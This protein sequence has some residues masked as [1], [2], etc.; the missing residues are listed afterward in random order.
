V[1]DICLLRA[2]FNVLVRKSYPRYNN[3]DGNWLYLS[4]HHAFKKEMILEQQKSHGFIPQICKGGGRIVHW[5][6]DSKY[7]GSE[8]ASEFQVVKGVSSI[9]LASATTSPKLGDT[10]TISG[11]LIPR[12][13]GERVSLRV[14]KPDG[15]AADIEEIKTAGP[16]SFQ[17]EILLDQKGEWAFKAIWEGDESYEPSSNEKLV[18]NV[19]K[20][21]GKVIIVLGGG[22]ESTNLAWD[23]FNSVANRVYK[24]FKRR[25]FTDDDIY[26]LSPSLKRNEWVDVATSL[27]ELKYAITQWANKSVNAYVPL[28]IYFLSHN[29]GE[30]FLLEKGENQQ[31]FLTPQKLDEWLN[32]LEEETQVFLIFEACHS[33][34]F[35]TAEEDGR[36][37]LP[38][39][40]E[41]Q[42]RIIITSAK[43]NKRDYC[44]T[45]RLS[46][47]TSLGR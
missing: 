20:E 36:P 47:N 8:R 40:D 9:T 4:H 39:W 45:C 27:L 42:R 35:I 37:I 17:Y 38:K 7:Q 24:A 23:T 5:A 43:M 12:L 11:E 18:L 28:Y 13:S 15:V 30:N 34:R 22:N 10:L 31:V 26:F 32:V 46:P 2:F 25:R 29:L 21:L 44:A 33:G 6:G 1:V 16:G 14:E 41:H 19:V 3:A